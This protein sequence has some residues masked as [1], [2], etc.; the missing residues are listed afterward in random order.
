MLTIEI[1][2]R[3][4]K[5][6]LLKA[7]ARLLKHVRDSSQDEY[8]LRLTNDYIEKSAQWIEKILE[9]DESSAYV[10]KNDGAPVGNIVG[11]MTR[12]FIQQC[13]IEKIGLI[14]HCWVEQEWRM[15]RIAA[16]LVRPIERWFKEHSIQYYRCPVLARKY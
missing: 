3:I 16:K 9:S 12:L 2:H 5:P 1:A 7:M 4:D 13:A 14:A 15:N 10:A 8:L 11:T 6:Y